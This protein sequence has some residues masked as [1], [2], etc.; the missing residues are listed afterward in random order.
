MKRF[1]FLVAGV[2]GVLAASAANAAT[3]DD[4][5]AK[6][7]VQCGVSQ[8]LPGF[9]N[10]DDAGNWAGIDVDVCRAVA[11]AGPRLVAQ[12]RVPP[13][14]AE[15]LRTRAG[16]AGVAVEGRPGRA[17]RA[18]PSDQR[19]GAAIHAGRLPPERAPVVPDDRAVPR[20]LRGSPRPA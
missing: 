17:P 1:S 13:A 3:L 19:G 20:S 9:S 18:R 12:R 5:R 2:A 15:R 11:A 6:G 7:F 16:A 10:A 8:G 14:D 4:V